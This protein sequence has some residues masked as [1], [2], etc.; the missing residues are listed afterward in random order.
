MN[1]IIAEINRSDQ[2]TKLDFTYQLIKH[3]LNRQLHLSVRRS[4]NRFSTTLLTSVY[5]IPLDSYHCLT[6]N[7]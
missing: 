2:L 4:D 7:H 1:V 5:C 3:T 6:L